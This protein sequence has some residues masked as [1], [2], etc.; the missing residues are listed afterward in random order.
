M[1]FRTAR[2]LEPNPKGI[3]H[4]KKCRECG[5]VI[6]YKAGKEWNEQQKSFRI[7][8]SFSK[9]NGKYTV[10]DTNLTVFYK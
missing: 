8:V 6:L 7:G 4:S 10:T 1:L 9:D 2:E 5:K 3:T